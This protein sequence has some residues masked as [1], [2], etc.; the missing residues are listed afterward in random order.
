ML[1]MLDDLCITI[2]LELID[3]CYKKNLLLK[4]A[5]KNTSFTVTTKSVQ[6]RKPALQQ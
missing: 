6:L 1:N 5:V 4:C 3:G 2:N